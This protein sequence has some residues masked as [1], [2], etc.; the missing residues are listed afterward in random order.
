MR[1]GGEEDK[2]VP[3]SITGVFG[4][5]HTHTHT[6]TPPHRGKGTLFTSQWY[7]TS[8]VDSNVPV[9]TPSTSSHTTSDIHTHTSNMY[10]DT[11]KSRTHTS[12]NTRTQEHTPFSLFPQCSLCLSLPTHHNIA[13]MH[14]YPVIKHENGLVMEGGREIGRASCRER[15]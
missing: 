13:G 14:G 10:T 11:H 1:P 8:P 9:G 15:V 5:T 7:M 2:G 6:H 4:H 3:G 12:V